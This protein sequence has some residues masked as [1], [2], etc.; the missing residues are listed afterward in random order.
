V[1]FLY[2][3]LALAF[4]VYAMH[5]RIGGGEGALVNACQVSIGL[6][7]VTIGAVTTLSED[8]TRGTL[9]LLLATPLSAR[10]IV[11]AKWFTAYRT[12]VLLVVLLAVLPGALGFAYG[13]WPGLGLLVGLV[14]G[15]GA[16]VTSLGLA[17]A[18]W[19]ASSSRAI[20]LA[21]IVYVLDVISFVLIL[22]ANTLG[23]QP[24]NRLERTLGLGSPWFG[25]G[26]VTAD[27]YQIGVNYSPLRADFQP[28]QNWAIGYGLA[29]ILLLGLTLATFDVSLGRV[30]LLGR[31]VWWRRKRLQ[32]RKI[33][34]ATTDLK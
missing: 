34:I 4:T 16:A 23:N 11:L 25:P 29:G 26:Q 20:A 1:W 8:Q 14:L 6:L 27:L 19:V 30:C 2:A 5:P 12:V 28:A 3:A 33:A 31:V 9:E 24:N 32:H 21:V 15:Y 13:G 17:V 22:I 7:F 18:T 10:S